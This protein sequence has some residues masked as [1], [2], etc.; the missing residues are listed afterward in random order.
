MRGVM[1]AT[2]PAPSHLSYRAV[3]SPST[4]P[5]L[6]RSWELSLGP[7]FTRVQRISHAPHCYLVPSAS[8]T[9][10]SAETC[11][12]LPPVPVPR[13]HRRLCSLSSPLLPS[14]APPL[15]LPPVPAPLWLCA[16]S[17]WWKSM[18][19]YRSGTR[20][21]VTWQLP[22]ARCTQ[23]WLRHCRLPIVI[24]TLMGRSAVVP[25]MCLP[26]S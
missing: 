18:G 15:R 24:D 26:Y 8:G 12:T 3:H 2:T 20:M 13:R 7:M 21:P 19:P 10:T 4:E 23:P 14:S 6:P 22:L 25:W 5:P 16:S 1:E 9:S 17:P 11:S